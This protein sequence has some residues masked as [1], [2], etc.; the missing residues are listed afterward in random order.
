MLEPNLCF[1]KRQFNNTPLKINRIHI[2]ITKS[3]SNTT[4][5]S[6]FKPKA[7][8]KSRLQLYKLIHGNMKLS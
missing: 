1:G 2:V 7:E 8:L 5:I 6:V 3:N 4:V